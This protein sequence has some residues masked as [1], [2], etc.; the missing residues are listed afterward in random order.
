ML[1]MELQGEPTKIQAPKNSKCWPLRN[2]L[3]SYVLLLRAPHI[4]S[5][6]YLLGMPLLFLGE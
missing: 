5:K 3:N 6:C 1:K 2:T 4:V